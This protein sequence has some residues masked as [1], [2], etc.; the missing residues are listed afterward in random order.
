MGPATNR[1]LLGRLLTRSSGLM[2][3]GTGSRGI[4]RGRG[5]VSWSSY[6]AM[7]CYAIC[8]RLPLHCR[9]T[10]AY[11]WNSFSSACSC[12]YVSSGFLTECPIVRSSL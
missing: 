11:C 1:G 10:T 12:A 6:Y 2:D 3:G 4:L 9:L 8:F 5:T 7:L